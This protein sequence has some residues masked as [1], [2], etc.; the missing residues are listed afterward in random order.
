MT[1]EAMIIITITM[2]DDETASDEVDADD[3]DGDDVSVYGGGSCG[4]CVMR[5]MAVGGGGADIWEKNQ[6][7]DFRERKKGLFVVLRA[8]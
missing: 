3:D 6:N 5:E 4:I 8:F 2:E 1:A 7:G